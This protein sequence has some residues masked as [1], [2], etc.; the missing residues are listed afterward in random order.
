MKNFDVFFDF[1]PFENM[2]CVCIVTEFAK[3]RV[4]ENGKCHLSIRY[5]GQWTVEEESS[6]TTL[7][8]AGLNSAWNKDIAEHLKADPEIQTFE[9]WIHDLDL[10]RRIIDAEIYNVAFAR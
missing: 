5:R 2:N 7:L 4:L 1:D 10:K 3:F 6:L 9:D 8:A